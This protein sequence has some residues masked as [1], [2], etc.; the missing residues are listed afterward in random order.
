MA[1]KKSKKGMGIGAYAVL[2]ARVLLGGLLCYAGYNKLM[3]VPKFASDIAHF[4]LLPVP[5]EH[6]L[7]IILPWNE[8]VVGAMLIFGI[9]TRAV[10]LASLLF[11]TVFAVAVSSAIAR[12]LNIECGCLGNADASKVGVLTLAKDAVGFALA[13]FIY[14]QSIPAKVRKPN[15]K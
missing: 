10:A 6:F 11:F 9:W 5:L 13:L 14:V 8:I 4:R 12:H 15:A 2:V 3:D 1:A 7:A